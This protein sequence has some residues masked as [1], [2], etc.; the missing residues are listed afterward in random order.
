[1]D[2]EVFSES[3]DEHAVSGHRLGRHIEHDER[4]RAFPAAR[5]PKVVSVAHTRHCPP[6]DQGQTGSCTGNAEAGV[7][8]T[9][10]LFVTGR[11]L[12]ESDAVV[13]YEKATHLDRIKGSYPPDDTGSSGLAVMKAAKD[14]GYITGYRHAFGLQHALEALVLAPVITGVSWYE[15]FD[16]PDADGTVTISGSIRGG[17][18][19]E[20]VGIDSDARTVR[21]CNS[22]GTDWGDRGYFQFSW[23]TW[24]QLLH[25]RGDVTTV[26]MAA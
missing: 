10:P 7:L 5:A 8:M 23:D 26:T 19:F 22:W 14:L 18:E 6:F 17:H 13:L 20:V 4:S 12:S 1:M 21:A 24:D 11:S 25:E 2:D 9:D 3:L 16:S 15:G